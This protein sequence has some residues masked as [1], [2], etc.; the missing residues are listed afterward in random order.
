MSQ[1][2]EICPIDKF[3]YLLL[4]SSFFQYR[5]MIIRY[6]IAWEKSDNMCVLISHVITANT[7]VSVIV[8]TQ[9]QIV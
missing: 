4:T 8:C 3:Q 7:L 5:N 9:Y 6:I 1:D 2:Q